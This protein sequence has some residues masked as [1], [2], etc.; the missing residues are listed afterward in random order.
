MKATCDLFSGDSSPRL[1]LVSVHPGPGVVCVVV[2]LVM[3]IMMIIMMMIIMMIIMMMMMRMQTLA[4][5][6]W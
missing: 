1:T 2:I 5:A 6:L 4:W 3:V